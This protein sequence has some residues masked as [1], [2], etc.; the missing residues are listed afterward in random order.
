MM[1]VVYTIATYVPQVCSNIGRTI[2]AIGR[3]LHRLQRLGLRA[4]NALVVKAPAWTQMRRSSWCVT[5]R[6]ASHS[7]CGIEILSG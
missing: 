4:L 3:I 7:R 5:G 1:R 6:S 2:D